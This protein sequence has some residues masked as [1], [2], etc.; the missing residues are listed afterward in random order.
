M[1]RLFSILVCAALLRTGSASAQAGYYEAPPATAS[2]SGIEAQPLP[3]PPQYETQPTS[4]VPSQGMAASP[5]E[6]PEERSLDQALGNAAP[7]PQPKPLKPTPHTDAA[8]EDRITATVLAPGS[9]A[10]SSAPVPHL[11]EPQT[12]VVTGGMS[13]PS[14]VAPAPSRWEGPQ[15]RA[16]DQ[17][18]PGTNL[19]APQGVPDVE[20]D[21]VRRLN[22]GSLNQSPPGGF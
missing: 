6:G 15:E 9:A 14:S 7:G 8:I 19:V 12:Q 2:P 21:E 4:L 11:A 20:E 3:P 13:Y 18:L 16:L 5:N 17:A 1:N 22:G 10:S